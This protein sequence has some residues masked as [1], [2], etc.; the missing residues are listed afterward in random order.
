M[1]ALFV[2]LNDGVN[3]LRTWH[4]KARAPQDTSTPFY[5]GVKA[6]LK[7]SAALHPGL[8]IFRKAWSNFYACRIGCSG[9]IILPW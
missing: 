8:T 7:V 4:W 3:V 5:F 1:L 6:I 2:L 9:D